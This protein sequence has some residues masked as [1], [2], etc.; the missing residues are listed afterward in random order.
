MGRPQRNRTASV[1]PVRGTLDK[2]KMLLDDNDVA[3]PDGTLFYFDGYGVGDRLLEGVMFEAS[4][5]DNGTVLVVHGTDANSYLTQLNPEHWMDCAWDC[6]AASDE[7]V[8]NNDKSADWAIVD[9]D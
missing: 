5:E 7:E 8:T 3:L 4:L 9:K 6:L 1:N 2:P